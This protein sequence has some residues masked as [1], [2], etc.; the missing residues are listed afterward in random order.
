MRDIS[1]AT[2]FSNR[3]CIFL[4]I[5]L[6][7]SISASAPAFAA[8]TPPALRLEDYLKRLEYD[9]VPFETSARGYYLVSSSLS[10]GKKPTFAVDTGWLI[11]M[12]IGA[13]LSRFRAMGLRN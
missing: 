9:P 10:N 5:C 11:T 8:D 3:S 13:L 12:V 4:F 2:I 7:A 1:S 6:F